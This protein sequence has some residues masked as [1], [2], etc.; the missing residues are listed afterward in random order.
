MSILKNANLLDADQSGKAEIAWNTLINAIVKSKG[1]SYREAIAEAVRDHP[2]TH[3]RF[4]AEYNS[5]A[6]LRRSRRRRR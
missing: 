6:A 5:R 4:L 1:K 3:E 2:A